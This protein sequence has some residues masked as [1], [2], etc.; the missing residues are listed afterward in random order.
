MLICVQQCLQ[1]I[2]ELCERRHTH[3]SMMER[4]SES[5]SDNTTFTEDALDELL[6]LFDCFE[7]K[8]SILESY[9]QFVSIASKI[10]TKACSIIPSHI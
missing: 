8:W 5:P 7:E 2:T 6:G 1:L 9:R 4:G 3:L 10:Q